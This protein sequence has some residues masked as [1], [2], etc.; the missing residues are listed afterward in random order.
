MAFDTQGVR[1]LVVDDDKELADGLVEYLSD[2][3]YSAVAAYSGQEGLNRFENGAFQLVITDLKMPEMDGIEFLEAV[4]ARDRQAVVMVITGHGTI[5]SAVKA[6]KK[7]AYDFIT[8][9]VKMEELEVIINR[10]LERHRLYRQLGV[11]RGL[12]LALII[13]V[14]LWLILG[15]VF[16]VL[17]KR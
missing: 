3:G 7:G 8:K 9:P 11:F 2:L 12:T 16:A 10:A 1:I 17:W 15:I 14:P 13:S 5:E 6:T 4:K